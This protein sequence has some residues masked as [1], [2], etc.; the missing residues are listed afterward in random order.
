MSEALTPETVRKVARLAR[1]QL[2]EADV[3]RFTRQLGQVLGYVE[4]L[5]ELNTDGVEPLAHPLEIENVLREDEPTPSL[6][7][8]AALSNSP[9]SDGKYF[10]VP[11]IL[12]AG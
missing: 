5:S 11:Q 1:I 6:S 10:L 4:M 9:K 8:E 7:R 12:D 2:T 3:D